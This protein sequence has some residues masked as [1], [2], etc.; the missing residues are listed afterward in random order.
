MFGYFV[1]KSKK[2]KKALVLLS[3]LTIITGIFVYISFVVEIAGLT[4]FF[5]FLM[6][7]AMIPILP[8]GFEFG[9]EITYPINEVYSTGFQLV[10]GSITGILLVILR[11]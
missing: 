6:G 7:S 9:A 8:I 2:F 3:V 5:S 1:G 11:F 4:A 10:F